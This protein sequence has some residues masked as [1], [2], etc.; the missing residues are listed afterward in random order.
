MFQR[1]LLLILIISSLACS[2]EKNQV[3]NFGSLNEVLDCNTLNG[4][5]LKYGVENVFKS[6]DMKEKIKKTNLEKYGTTNPFASNMI[7]DK[8]RKTCLEKY[9]TEF[10]MKNELIVAKVQETNMKKYGVSYI[11]V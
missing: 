7:K 9:G 6:E 8:L 10:P 2:Q 4:L 11:P 3:Q 1:S 5:Q